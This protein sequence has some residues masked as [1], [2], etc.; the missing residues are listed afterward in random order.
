MKKII[1]GLLVLPVLLIGGRLFW[2]AQKSSTTPEGMGLK[3]GLLRSCGDRPNCV[4]SQAF[5]DS[6]FYIKPLQADSL[7]ELWVSLPKTLSDLGFQKV[8]ETDNYLHYTATTK[9]MRFVDDMEFHK[10]E[11]EG[12][13]DMRSQSRVGYS[14]LGA[15]RARLEQLREALKNK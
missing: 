8:T 7:E 6:A 2:L 13:I 14:D 1:M 9:I 10:N 11:A 12:R 15:N 5:Q 3:E 4:S